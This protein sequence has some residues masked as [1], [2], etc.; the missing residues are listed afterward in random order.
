[1]M[2]TTPTLP[3]RRYIRLGPG[4]HNAESAMA[5][6]NERCVVYRNHGELFELVGT[7]DKDQK[8]NFILRKITLQR[9][10]ILM[11]RAADFAKLDR[12]GDTWHR[13][14]APIK[15]AR[16]IME[17]PEMW[18]FTQIRPPDPILLTGGLKS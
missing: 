15:L 14:D 13:V 4:W 18:P 2:P 1:M 17:R 8:F 16:A 11:D 7:L 10:L 12:R 9:L 5:A 3:D 6:L